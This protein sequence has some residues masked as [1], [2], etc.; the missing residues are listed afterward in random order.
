MKDINETQ[1]NKALEL[2]KDL[3]E[4]FNEEEAEAFASSHQDKT[5]YADFMLL[6]NMVMDSEYTISTRTKLLIGGTLAYVI[7]PIDI[8]PDLLPIIGWLD[9][10]FVIGYTMNALSDEI[11]AYKA[12]KGMA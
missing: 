3:A 9:D 4:D 6:L 7:L 11:V 12:F 1:K 8:I 10:A 2:T 5:W